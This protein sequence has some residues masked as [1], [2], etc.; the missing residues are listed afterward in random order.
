MIVENYR[1]GKYLLTTDP[2]KTDINAVCEMLGK[3]YWAS[4]RKREVIEV[5]IKNSLC[6][7]LYDEHKQIG[8]ARMIT[9]HATFAYLCDVYIEEE[10]RG[11]GLGKWLLECI[12]SYPSFKNIKRIDLSTSNAHELYRKYGFI[13]SPKPQNMMMKINNDN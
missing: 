11:Q 5:S 6:F 7:N 2:E 1:L 13:E 8:I 4:T 12:L 3:S 10:Y 9:D